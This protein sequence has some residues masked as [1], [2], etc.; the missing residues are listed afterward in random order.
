MGQTEMRVG[1]RSSE[2]GNISISTSTVRDGVSAQISIEHGE[3]AR[4]LATHLPEMQAKL[5]GNQS[6]DVRIDLNGDRGGQGTGTT[7]SGSNGSTDDM[8]GNRR[9]AGGYASSNQGN[10]FAGGSISPLAATT[11]ASDGRL[12]ARLDIRA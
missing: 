11:A 12:S 2:F 7:G 10:S 9:Q 6:G 3:L 1:M 5:G 4:T 8:R